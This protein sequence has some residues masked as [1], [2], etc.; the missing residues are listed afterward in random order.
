MTEKLLKKAAAHTDMAE[1]IA[2]QSTGY[3][4][5]FESGKLKS[6]EEKK[7]S[8]M[9]LRVIADGR[10]GF[11]ST[12]QSDNHDQLVDAAIA[13]SRF[14]T[15]ALFDFPSEIPPASPKLVDD[16]V[17]NYGLEEA[18]N[19]GQTIIELIQD[20]H[21]EVSTNIIFNWG[22]IETT[23]HN[24]RGFYGSAKRSSFIVHVIGLLIGDDS[25][26]WVMEGGSYGSL[27]LDVDNIVSE[28]NR[29]LDLAKNTAQISTGPKT[30]IF[31]APQLPTLLT[32]IEMG[33]DGFQLQKGATPLKDREGKKIVSENITIDDNP[34]IP[35][36]VGSRAFDDEGV[37]MKKNTVFLNGVFE[38]FLFDLKTAARM[39]KVSTGSA[40]R[41]FNAQP[42]IGFS[43]LVLKTGE[44]TLEDMIRNIDDGLLVYETL[45]G[46]QSNMLNGDFSMN[47]MLGYKIEK[48]EITGRVRDV[49]ISGNVYDLFGRVQSLGN[50]QFEIGN[51]Y[52]PH[53]SLEGVRV[54]AK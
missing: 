51:C 44:S 7:T 49:M 4:V 50:K 26:L 18:V 15:E 19:H 31:A 47:V 48:G 37:S 39:G 8:G 42:S 20:R 25:V 43:N 14:G 45:G 1:V 32:T 10:I 12:T 38:G 21:P 11:S 13:G 16:H 27:K 23:I 52:I 6:I 54:T 35:F 46:G 29:K 9:G 41:S 2:L 5:N 53:I 24:S 33:V 22:I 34:A 28:I 36:G 3:I 17:L 40:R 30:V